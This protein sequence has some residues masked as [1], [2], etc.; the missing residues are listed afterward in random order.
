MA[1]YD[2]MTGLIYVYSY[3]IIDRLR[4]IQIYVRICIYTYRY[5]DS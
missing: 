5:A 3:N 1:Y 2:E 4:V